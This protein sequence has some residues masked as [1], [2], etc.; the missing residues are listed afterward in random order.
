MKPLAN[1]TNENGLA[2][3]ISYDEVACHLY[4][5]AFGEPTEE[6]GPKFSSENEAANYIQDSWGRNWNLTWRNA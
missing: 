4:T 2:I 5:E 6:V 3:T 1:I